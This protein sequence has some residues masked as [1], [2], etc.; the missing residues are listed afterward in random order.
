MS[1][2][3]LD[4]MK[5][6]LGKS[7][8]SVNRNKIH[9][10]KAEVAFRE[11][12]T[13]LG[14]ADRVS[15]GGWIAR[16]TY[17]DYG[18]HIVALFPETIIPDTN[19]TAAPTVGDVPIGLH[20]ICSTMHQLGVKSYYS[21]PL[22]DV[23][24]DTSSI[25]WSTLQLG[26]PFTPENSPLNITGAAFTPRSRNYNFLRYNSDVSELPDSI[27]PEE[28]T[29][30]HLRVSFQNEFMAE[31]S[32]IDGIF[33]GERHTYPVEIKEKSAARDNDMGEWF[34]LDVGPFVKLAFYAAKKENLHSI[35]VVREVDNTE[36]RN[37][38]GWWYITFDTLAQYAGWTPR[39]G[40]PSMGGGRSA[41]VRIPKSA[42]S[43]FN[44][45]AIQ[46]L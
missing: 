20:T 7:L 23:M 10:I 5:A 13:T 9:G 15:V 42:F 32:D 40:G 25:S 43:P 21:R 33:W 2:I 34:G 44:I 31:I 24:D 28:F 37:F 26:V 8:S 35:F 3:N 30:E 27:I 41:V 46:S 45:E 14:Y 38:I 22:V 17:E 18:H 11:Y 36:E 29:K 1:S 4:E 12:L 19:Y 6:Y 16:N 39:G